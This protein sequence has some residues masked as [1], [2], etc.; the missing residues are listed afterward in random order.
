MQRT[1]S[2]KSFSSVRMVMDSALVRIRLIHSIVSLLSCVECRVP[3]RTSSRSS[4]SPRCSRSRGTKR[5]P[6]YTHIISRRADVASADD[7]R[8]ILDDL[9][10]LGADGLIADCGHQHR[11]QLHITIS[12]QSAPCHSCDALPRRSGRRRAALHGADEASMRLEAVFGLFAWGCVQEPVREL[13]W[14]VY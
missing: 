6:P 11:P 14:H 1:R 8:W 5:L 2:R 10:N 3:T 9:G 7:T 4:Q 13:V 12:A